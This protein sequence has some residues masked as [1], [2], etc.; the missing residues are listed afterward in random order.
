MEGAGQRQR[1]P[2][3]P[4]PT[5]APPPAYWL[6][7]P[8]DGQAKEVTWNGEPVR[9]P[10]EG[11]VLEEHLV[12]HFGNYHSGAV[13]ITAVPPE[14]PLPVKPVEVALK[15]CPRKDCDFR[16]ADPAVLRD[17]L[18]EHVKKDGR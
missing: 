9:L 2:E 15:A 1:Y 11:A 6:V 13:R 14:I 16:S 4:D 12:R 5:P 8:L 18:I 7:V 10:G 3:D 17:H